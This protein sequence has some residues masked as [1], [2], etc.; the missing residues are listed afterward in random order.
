M[1]YVNSDYIKECNNLKIIASDVS[2][3]MALGVYTSWHSVNWFDIH[4]LIISAN[5]TWQ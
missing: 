4:V 5:K 1:N 2:Q 3:N